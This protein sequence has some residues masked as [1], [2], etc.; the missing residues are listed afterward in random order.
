MPYTYSPLRY[1]GGK[2]QLFEF[3]AHT[4]EINHF[5]DYTYCE[6]FCGGAGVAIRL[7]FSGKVNKIILNDADIAIYSIWRAILHDKE[8]FVKCIEET[9]I[10]IQEWEKQKEIY[11]KLKDSKSYC[12]DLAWAAFFLNRTNRSGIIKGGP[13]GGINQNSKYKLDC[14]FNKSALI[15]KITNIN[16]H[17]KAIELHHEDGL[18]F[19]D[20]IEQK[21]E[22]KIFLFLDPPYFKQGKKLYKA[23]AND[24]YHQKLSKKIKKLNSP[25]VLT[26]DDVDEVRKIYYGVTGWRYAIN[27]SANVKRKE[28]ELIFKS[29]NVI[30]ESYDKVKLSEL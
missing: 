2:S 9:K 22:D 7:L 11:S 16:L 19:I 1:P 14:R 20:W 17:K 29:E 4:L 24:K 30:L 23:F 18:K 21:Y 15:E 5:I 25:W 28:Y 6:P 27:Y 12:F 10:D 8:K 3:I 26:Y 13:I